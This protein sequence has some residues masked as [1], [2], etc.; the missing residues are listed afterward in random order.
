MARDY[1]EVRKLL[2]DGISQEVSAEDFDDYE[3]RHLVEAAVEGDTT[4]YIADSE[5][6]DEHDVRRI[7]DEGRENVVFR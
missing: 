5:N 7:A 1:Y 6:L 4:L 2:R 3:L